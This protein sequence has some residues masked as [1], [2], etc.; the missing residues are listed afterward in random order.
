MRFRQ[1]TRH[2][3]RRL[4]R[5]RCGR[6]STRWLAGRFSRRNLR[7]Q[8]QRRVVHLLLAPTGSRAA[9]GIPDIPGVAG[10][11]SRPL[12]LE[13]S[14]L[15][16]ARRCS[17]G[18]FPGTVQQGPVPRDRRRVDAQPLGRPRR[19]RSCRCAAG[20]AGRNSYQ[21]TYRSPYIGFRLAVNLSAESNPAEQKQEA[22]AQQRPQI[23]KA[24]GRAAR[25]REQR[26]PG[27]PL[28]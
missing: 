25:C 15:L 11:R 20:S 23:L 27:L 8:A 21:P 2:L 6:S 18:F 7:L 4:A 1:P 17:L 3:P 9:R 19:H 10:Y 5:W 13:K 28:G 14:V 22:G 24:H 16:R 12:K 26:Y